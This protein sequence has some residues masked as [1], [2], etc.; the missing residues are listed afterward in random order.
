MTTAYYESDRT[1]SCIWRMSTCSSSQFLWRDERRSLS[2]NTFVAD[3][4]NDL[5]PTRN[6]DVLD[7][8]EMRPCNELRSTQ[9]V[10]KVDRHVSALYIAVMCYARYL[11]GS[12]VMFIDRFS[13][14]IGECIPFTRSYSDQKRCLFAARHQSTLPALLSQPVRKLFRAETPLVRGQC[15]ALIRSEKD[16]THSGSVKGA[17]RST[18]LVG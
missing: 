14:R 16:M 18:H 5:I 3:E 6:S 11:V 7:I 8:I 9:S 17:V 15:F 2:E 13:T 12:V 10:S 1:G 4:L